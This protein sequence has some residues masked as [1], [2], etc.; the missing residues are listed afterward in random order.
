MTP[1]LVVG[2]A[3]N[4]PTGLARIARDLTALMQKDTR[5][6]LRVG[7]LG[8]GYDGSPWP[9]AC[10]PVTDADNWASSDIERTL[11]WHRGRADEIIVLTVWDP[12]R[13]H[14]VASK[15]DQLKHAGYP[16]KLWGYFAVDGED[17]HG[18][19]GG[20][21]AD[22]VRK[23]DRILAYGRYGKRVLKK[24]TDRR[25][26][27]LPHGFLPVAFNPQASES[28]GVPS[29]D[30]LPPTGVM[31]GCVAAN[32]PRKDLGLVFETI[33]AMQNMTDTPVQLWL[34]TDVDI[35]EGAWCIPLLH[36]LYPISLVLSYDLTDKQLAARYTLCNV[37]VA[38]GLGEGFGYPIIESLACGTPVVHGQYGG[39][40][41]LIPRL[42]WQHPPTDYRVDPGYALKRPVYNA[43]GL[44]SRLLEAA[45]WKQQPHAVSYCSGSVAHLQW[46]SLWRYWASWIK[47]GL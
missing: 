41:D 47:G 19:F 6:L 25:V 38:P 4:R 22:A 13:C 29:S 14:E 34:H 26:D 31:V 9:W 20:P 1:L 44:A 15:I 46:K 8:W 37:T 10:Y 36:E 7:Q 45:R 30:W 35:K 17:T 2:D 39:G 43:G 16:V 21:A 27:W 23:Y 40:V 32:Q 42:E 3:P 5:L 18:G 33:V 28:Q 12:A 11:E 24:V